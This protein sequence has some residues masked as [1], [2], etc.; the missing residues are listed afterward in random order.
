MGGGFGGFMHS[1]DVTLSGNSQMNNI[2]RPC[3]MGETKLA[4]KWWCNS[5][6]RKLGDSTHLVLAC[7]VRIWW[8]KMKE[9]WI[10]VRIR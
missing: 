7:Y 6:S 8:E 10:R 5:F 4:E 3:N 1:F 2:V 9:G